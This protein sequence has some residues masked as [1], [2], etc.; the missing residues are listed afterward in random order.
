MWMDVLLVEDEDLLREIL[1]E[2]LTDA[3]LAVVMAATAEEALGAAGPGTGPPAV[4]VTDV[5]LGPGM[6]GLALAEEVERRWPGVGVVVVTGD[7]ANLDRR[8]PRPR[9]RHL[10]KPFTPP[11]LLAAVR[12]LM[13]A[14]AA[15]RGP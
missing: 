7:W 13:G 1:G 5:N 11:H 9:E 3:G 14:A 12:S 10:R 2:N 4:V 8:P 6:D 15:P